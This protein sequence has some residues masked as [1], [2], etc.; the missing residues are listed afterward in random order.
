[1]IHLSFVA[2]KQRQ[3]RQLLQQNINDMQFMQFCET[4]TKRFAEISQT[5][6]N[7]LAQYEE[8][9][10]KIKIKIAKHGRIL[11]SLEKEKLQLVK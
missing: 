10:D 8:S 7:L 3:F 2:F 4:T 11:Q 9:D 5:I 6:R 1:M